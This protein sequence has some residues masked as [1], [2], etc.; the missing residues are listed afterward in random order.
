MANYIWKLRLNNAK[1]KSRSLSVAAQVY[2]EC[3]PIMYIYFES[4]FVNVNVCLPGSQCI[5]GKAVDYVVAFCGFFDL[6][7]SHESL[8]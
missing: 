4:V 5:Y 7:I 2:S 1:L 8:M 6:S 3:L